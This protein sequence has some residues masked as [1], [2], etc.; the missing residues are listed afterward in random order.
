MLKAPFIFMLLSGIKLSTART[1][2]DKDSGV[3]I[4]IRVLNAKSGKPVGAEKVSVAIKGV[5]NASEYKTDSDGSIHLMISFA[6][7]I[8]ASTEWWRTCKPLYPYL[9]TKNYSPV[10]RI[11]QSGIVLQNTCGKA[12]SE[13]H[14]GELV[15][16]AR[17]STFSENMAR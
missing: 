7:E 11:F 2:L 16:F 12:Q 9:D 5:I 8:T 3:L 4:K 10:I 14:K 6:S 1:Q 13:A 17:K 15:I